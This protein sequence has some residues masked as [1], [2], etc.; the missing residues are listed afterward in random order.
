VAILGVDGAGRGYVVAALPDHEVRYIDDLDQL[1]AAAVI[2]VDIPLGFPTG[3]HR[4]PAEVAASSRLHG[5][6]SSVFW[7]LPKSVYEIQTERLSSRDGYARARAEASV[8]TGGRWSISAQGWALRSKILAAAR[9]RQGG[10]RLIE[11][12]P[13][14]SFAVMSE[15][16]ADVRLASKKSWRGQRQRMDLLRAQG[17]DPAAFTGDSGPALPD[18]V[19]DAMAAAWTAQRFENGVAECLGCGAGP[20]DVPIWA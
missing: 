18:D 16:E 2:A 11:V 9:A 10:A 1:P 7:T 19:L 13:E 15:L 12:H 14:V 17:I 6:S 5:R 4:R 20:G 8:A 3:D